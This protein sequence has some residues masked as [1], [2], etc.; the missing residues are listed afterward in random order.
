ML[1][2][3]LPTFYV[4]PGK[5]ESHASTVYF[6]QHG[7]EPNPVYTLRYPDPASPSS[8]NRYAIALVDPFVP[9]VVYGEVLLA[10]EFTQPS[11]S[12]DSIRQNGGVAPPPELIIPT[13]FTVRLYNP[14]QH[15]TVQFKPKSWN[16]PATW[17]FEMPQQTFRQPSSSTLDQSRI[18]PATADTTPKLRF[19]WRRD[20]KLSKDL[21][22]LLSGK[23][24]T[25]PETKT[26]SKEPDITVSIFRS[27]RELTLYEPNLYRVEME[28]FKGLEVVLLLGAVTIRDVFFE[29]MKDAF[30][31]SSPKP[32][33]AASANK[34]LPNP[35]GKQPQQP[36]P[37]PAVSG[38]L[39]GKAPMGTTTS[40]QPPPQIRQ[41]Q[42]SRE[43]ER[44]RRKMKEEQ[45]QA[46]RRRQEEVDKETQRLQQI[47][48][49]EEQQA[50]AQ[51][52]TPGLPPRPAAP[53]VQA[54]TRPPPQSAVPPRGAPAQRFY[55]HHHHSPSV[56]HIVPVSGRPQGTAA[57]PQPTVQPKK[58][59][60]FGFRRPPSDEGKLSKKRSSMF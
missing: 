56:P 24:A 22:C 37:V 58:S 43:E 1:D 27:L 53:P 49:R 5:K 13:R 19:S 55:H 54:S 42:P 60:F 45:E 44:R 40:N 6:C 20:S 30:H 47:Y 35:N 50:R 51:A 2:E 32:T 23:T 28:D 12:A 34:P 8:S 25:I 39:K 11:L 18:D 21:T 31:L 46:R 29:T 17:T 3:N 52:R 9:D 57:R 14:D 15:I 48:G 38:G 7:N 4:K 36:Q 26:K 59:S 10:P 33:N 16:S 41:P